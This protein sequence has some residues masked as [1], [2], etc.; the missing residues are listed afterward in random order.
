MNLAWAGAAAAAALAATGCGVFANG[1]VSD[2]LVAEGGT[3]GQARSLMRQGDDAF[4]RG[5][6]DNAERLYRRSLE[7]VP[8][9]P[10]VLNNLGNVLV[11]QGR[12]LD[13]EEVFKRAIVVDASRPEVFTNRGGLW[14]DAKWP[15]E[16]IKHFDQALELDPRYLPA[17]RGKATAN[18]VIGTVDESYL[19]EL[20]TAILIEADPEWRRFFDLERLRVQQALQVDS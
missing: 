1:E 14:L 7:I 16:A 12:Y 6:F 19:G 17:L 5:E 20:R 8:D 2:M 4:D 9:Q 13:A 10:G 11:E 3:I 18:H 15:R